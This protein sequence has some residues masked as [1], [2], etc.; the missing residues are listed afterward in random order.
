MDP[1]I[2]S[3]RTLSKEKSKL[4][5][6]RDSECLHHVGEGCSWRHY[7]DSVDG[8]AFQAKACYMELLP[9]KGGTEGTRGACLR[10][11]YRRVTLMAGPSRRWLFTWSSCPSRGV[12]E[13]SE[14]RVLALHTKECEKGEV[15]SREEGHDVELWRCNPVLLP[16]VQDRCAHSNVRMPEGMTHRR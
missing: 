10:A 9:A 2:G 5:H 8:V 11:A 3:N 16:V 7:R 15:A 13:G 4:E 14:E 12:A 6:G 1:T